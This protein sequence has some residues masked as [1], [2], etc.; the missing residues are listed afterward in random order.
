MAAMEAEHSGTDA[1]RHFQTRPW[2]PDGDSFQTRANEEWLFVAKDEDSWPR[3]LDRGREI[4][5]LRHL[6]RR[7]E[8]T[9]ARLGVEEVIALRLAAGPMCDLY[10]M[11]LR[12]DPAGPPPP[13]V[14][15]N[16][17]PATIRAL[18]SALAKLSRAPP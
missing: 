18:V 5:Q 2:A 17:Y 3:P 15:T 12:A 13:L 10:N 16:R 1:Q 11:A 7:A 14:G 6:R 4:V 8:A 9:R